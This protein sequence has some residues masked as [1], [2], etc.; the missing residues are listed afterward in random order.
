MFFL[1]CSIPSF[2]LLLC[3]DIV[4]KLCS[5]NYTDIIQ[6]INP[7]LS[8]FSSNILSYWARAIPSVTL[9]KPALEIGYNKLGE[10]GGGRGG[11]LS[12][13]L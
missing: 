3:L 13:T 12:T 7:F 10:G 6:R 5:Y 2:N 4:N 8:T 1:G 9:I 11:D